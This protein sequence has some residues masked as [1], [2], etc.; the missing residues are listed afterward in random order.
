MATRQRQPRTRPRAIS[1]DDRVI[2]L[3]GEESYLR[4][5]RLRELQ[6]ELTPQGESDYDVSLFQGPDIDLDEL[7]SCCDTLPMLCDRRLVVGRDGHRQSSKR[8]EEEALLDIVDD[9]H[10]N[11][12][13]KFLKH[14]SG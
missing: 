8:L 6:T 3:S 11:R 10:L 12:S 2:L 5:R 4:D 1:P 14:N 9:V 13:L 7:V